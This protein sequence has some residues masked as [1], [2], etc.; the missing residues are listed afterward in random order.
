MHKKIVVIGASA[1]SM[2]FISKFRSFNT[3]DTIIC[4]SAESSLPYNRCLLADCLVQEKDFEGIQLKSDNF[5]ADH[6]VDL[7][8][9]SW[10]SAINREEK[11]LTVNGQQ[12]SYDYLFIGI[13]T[14]PFIPKIPGVD[15]QGV[16]GFH[17]YASV[18][19]L[20]TFLQHRKPQ[21]AVVV[22]GGINGIEVTSALVDRG[23]TVTLVDLYDTIMAQQVNPSTA[24][25]IEN[26]AQ[27]AGVTIMKRQKVVSL[28]SRDQSVLSRIQFASG[29]YLPTDCVVLATGSRP[30][31][32][33][34]EQAGLATQEGYLLV[35]AAMQTSDAA[36]YG[37]GDIC[38]VPDMVSK[39]LVKSCTWADAMLQG[40]TAAT[41]F[42]D[43]PRSYP[44]AVGMRDS[45]FFGK[46]F[47]ACGQ[48]V[49]TELFEA[50]TIKN[51]DYL[52]V[53]YLFDQQLQGFV[54]IGNVEKIGYYR[55][56][57]ITAQCVTKNDFIGV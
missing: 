4:F 11:Y 8:L 34:I 41:Q 48:T 50:I 40:L 1:A 36:I 28:Q 56:L 51:D 43:A 46:E 18:A 14:S 16:F 45:E 21:H 19:Q 44:G 13:G 25:Y 22:G 35:N 5:F 49:D 38:M 12:E 33:L 32:S 7:R 47:Y 37:G 52:H 39:E 27:H 15:L 9:H 2:G 53:F 54:L 42:S 20:D 29:A 3:T 24:M 6:H 57:Y 26:L 30:N 31:S 23:V 17:T 10:V 55:T